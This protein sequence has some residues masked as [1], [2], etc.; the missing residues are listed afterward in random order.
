MSPNERTPGAQ[1]HPKA[2]PPDR[3]QQV[4]QHQHSMRHNMHHGM[5]DRMRQRGHQMDPDKKHYHLHTK[6]LQ[7]IPHMHMED[8]NGQRA[9]HHTMMQQQQQL[10]QHHKMHAHGG[11]SRRP[12]RQCPQVKLVVGEPRASQR[13]V[14]PTHT[15]REDRP[16]QQHCTKDE[17]HRHAHAKHKHVHQAHA[18]APHTKKH[19]Q[20]TREY[21]GARNPPAAAGSKPWS[22]HT[23]HQ[24]LLLQQHVAASLQAAPC[25]AR[26][27]KATS[28]PWRTHQRTSVQ[29]VAAA[30][31]RQEA[32]AQHQKKEIVPDQRRPSQRT[33]EGKRLTD[34][35]KLRFGKVRCAA[36]RNC[37]PVF[38]K[39]RT[40]SDSFDFSR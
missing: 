39:Y 26:R 23:I 31:V 25:R 3:R 16:Q 27:M 40:A 17:A 2:R 9:V 32:R 7:R 8:A 21:V 24:Q 18:G 34:A 30:R 28:C 5:S 20:H 29:Q 33:R 4:L 38:Q 22:I 12:K 14:E 36:V 37:R 6:G 15:A 11:R 35:T 1:S 10:Q 13:A 19:A